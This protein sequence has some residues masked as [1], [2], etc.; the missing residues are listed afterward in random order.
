MLRCIELAKKGAG[1]VSPNPMVGSV[2][3]FE[4]KIIGEG[5]HEKF[6]EAHAEINAISSVKNKSLL[7]Y[8][9]IYVSLEPCSHYGKTPP[10]ALRII[11]EKI[12]RVVIGHQDPFPKVQGGGI[13]L[14]KEAGI[15]VITDILHDECA[16]LNKRFFTFHEK[17]RP[18][19]ILKWAESN[20]GFIDKTR[21]PENTKAAKIST[22]ETQILVHQ[23]RAEESAILVGTN[24]AIQDN[25]SLTVRLCA[26]NNP[27]RMA[28]D[29]DLKIPAHYNLFDRKAKT[30]IFTEKEAISSKNIEYIK[31]DFNQD[32]LPQIM[33]VLYKK[34]LLS[35]IV[36][37]GS[38]VLKSFIENV[39]WDEAQIETATELH[40]G[41]GV[42]APLLRNAEL[43]GEEIFKKNI[44]RK[45][46]NINR[47]FI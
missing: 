28:I 30:I 45:Y 44:I 43:I 15:E 7:P 37:G 46:K 21:T 36:E 9:T 20:D 31:L 24:T 4:D 1:N 42:K 13:K 41:E 14:L 40:F 47:M 10:C 6:G 29:K 22:E 19:V 32:I 5:Y 2:I 27:V 26:G 3:V 39:C 17:K 33:E 16:E 35:L 11:Q 12:P 25:P 23:M 8:S 34:E 38:Q 18:F